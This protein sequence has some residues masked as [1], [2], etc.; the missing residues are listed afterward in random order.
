MLLL[1]LESRPYH[2]TLMGQENHAGSNVINRESDLSL[3]LVAD[4]LISQNFKLRPLVE[5]TRDG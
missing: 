3:S 5:W 1:C 4:A 2:R